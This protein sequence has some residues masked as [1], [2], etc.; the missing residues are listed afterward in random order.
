MNQC[1][2]CG[3]PVLEEN[4]VILKVKASDGRIEELPFH[5]ECVWEAGQELDKGA[6]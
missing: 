5:W 6:G 1:A 2:W 3:G 4:R